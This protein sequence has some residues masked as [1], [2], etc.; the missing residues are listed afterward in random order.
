MQRFESLYMNTLQHT[1]KLKII[2]CPQQHAIRESWLCHSVL[3]F[4][5]Q[6]TLPVFPGLEAL[7]TK[8]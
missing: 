5:V 8:P 2:L 1:Q 7:S 3:L 6:L 4:V